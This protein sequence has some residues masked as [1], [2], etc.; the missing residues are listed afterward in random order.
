VHS[1]SAVAQ[2]ILAVRHARRE[3]RDR[4]LSVG[5]TTHEIAI[6]RQRSRTGGAVVSSRAMDARSRLHALLDDF[7]D[8]EVFA[9]EMYLLGILQRRQQ[10]ERSETE[11]ARLGER[12]E[13]FRKAAELRWQDAGHRLANSGCNVVGFGGGGGFGFDLQGRAIGKM[14]CEY[15]AGDRSFVETLR[16]VAGQEIEIAEQ[17]SVSDDNTSLSYQHVATSAGHVVKHEELFP[18]SEMAR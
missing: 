16:Y 18:F 1:A 10:P 8:E 3:V 7:N 6:S 14:S 4:K 5:R 2:Q 12:G 9:A 15:A 13:Q 11:I 17:F